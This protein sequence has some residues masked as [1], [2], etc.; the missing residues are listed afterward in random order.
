MSGPRQRNAHV[1]HQRVMDLLDAEALARDTL[2]FVQV[3]SET[4]AEGPGSEHFAALCERAGLEV[5]VDRFISDRPNVYARLPGTTP[6]RPLLLNGHVD[7][8]PRGDSDPP[9]LRDGWVVGRGAEDMKGGLV[10]MVHAAM[11]LR[12]AGVQLGSD[13][14]LTGVVGH[15]TPVG[16]KEGPKRL[17][18]RIRA[19]SIP[20][21]AVIIAEGPHAIWT[22]GLGAA[23]FRITLTSA[24][25][26]VHTLHVPYAANPARWAGAM[27]E[28]FAE[29]EAR[30]ESET[31]HPLCGRQ[32]VDIGLVAGGDYPNRLPT[33]LT[34]RGTRRWRHGLTAGDV[35]AELRGICRRI[36]E[37]S[38]LE[39]TYSLDAPHEPF[40]T[41]GDHALVRALESSA[42]TATGAPLRR[43][44]LALVTD[45]NIYANDASLP[46]VCCGP[47]YATAHSDHERVSVERLHRTAA[48]Y[49][50]A[51]MEFC[52]VGE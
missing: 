40:E 3:P 42:A 16:K 13:L 44:G 35:E 19:G 23:M 48:L 52:G 17:V 26:I 47:E 46:V 49:A 6:G 14:W 45:A 4:G 27:L 37:Q 51:A 7:T 41:P 10:A 1:M 32:R 30:F 36:E 5:E 12:L 25:G 20:A 29:W 9:A 28:E 8:I 21:A 15:E 38:G 39:A 43:I 24:R 11:A 22:A 31:P 33:P 18:E 2:A 34:L 50:L